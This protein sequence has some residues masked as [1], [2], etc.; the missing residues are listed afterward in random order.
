MVSAA[1][2]TEL[3]EQNLNPGD[4]AFEDGK[5]IPLPR[6]PS[7]SGTIDGGTP[8]SFDGSGYIEE[9]S[10][11]S[12]ASGDPILGI[13]LDQADESD[14]LRLTDERGDDNWYSV[15]VD[16]LPINIDLGE[17]ATLG[18]TVVADGAGGYTVDNTASPDDNLVVV[19]DA[20]SSSDE[21]VVL[22]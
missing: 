9:M 11:G 18:D 17:A 22:K 3:V 13:V 16:R 10:G 7:A 14:A 15:H 20:D 21:Y 19:K 2:P 1:D 5:T 6:D 8:V 12:Y 4:T